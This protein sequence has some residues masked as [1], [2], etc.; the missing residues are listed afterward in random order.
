MVDY[1]SEAE[2]LSE[3]YDG[4]EG[5][6]EPYSKSDRRDYVDAKSSTF[7]KSDVGKFVVIQKPRRK[8]GVVSVLYL[9]DRRL[10][11]RFWWSPDSFYAM[12]FENESAARI[13]ASKYRYNKASV[14]QIT[15]SMADKEWFTQ[16]YE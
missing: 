10:T 15:S 9:V 11:K 3:I 14:R 8:R 6:F 16:S 12:V 7:K 2:A 4:F 5:G 1:I 13:Q